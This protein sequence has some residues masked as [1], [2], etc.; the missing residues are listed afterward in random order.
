MTPISQLFRRITFCAFA[1]LIHGL[2][3]SAQGLE[4]KVEASL[5]SYFANFQSPYTQLKS[6]KLDR[7]ELNENQK[8]V[9][10]YPAANFGY[11][12]FTPQSTHTIYEQLR[13]S[14]PAELQNYTLCITC[15][16]K[17]IEE[18]IPNRLLNK[19][20]KERLWNKTAYKGKPWVENQSKPYSLD[21][22]LSNKHL[23]VW[24]SHGIYYKAEKGSWEFQRP[25]LFGTR[26]DLLTKE[27]VVPYLIPMLENAGATVF[28]PRERDYQ[29][30]EVI[31]DNDGTGTFHEK[32]S[33][34][35]KWKT[36]NNRGFALPRTTYLDGESPFREGTT[37]YAK[38]EKKADRAFAQWIPTFPEAGKY[39]VYV[40]YQSEPKSVEDAKYLVFHKGGVTEFLVN[41][42]MGGGTWVYLGSFEFEKGMNETGMV[43]LTNQ[44]KQKG[45]ISADAVRFGGGMGNIVRGGTTS[46]MPRYV[47]G[48]RYW[49]QWAGF[50]YE[51]YSPSE[52]RNDYTDDINV[53]G[54]SVNY[55]NGGSVFNPEEQGL[56]VPIELSFGFHTDAGFSKE[57]DFIGT[58]GIYTTDTNEGN[59]KAGPSRYTARD[60]SDGVLNELN[61]DLT[62]H[63]GRAWSTR[64]MWNRNYSE[65]RIPGVPAMILELLSH[66][67]FADLKQAYDPRFQFVVGRSI[68]KAILK[69]VATMH[70][71]SY[72]V[73]PLPV[74]HFAIQRGSKRGSFQ[75]HWQPVLDALEPTAT[76]ESYVVYTR[77][78]EGGFDN[79]K[80]VTKPEYNFQAEPGL[81]YSFKVTAVNRGGESF[82]SEILAAYQAPQGDKTVLIINNFNRLSGP[83]TIETTTQ[84]GFDLATDTGMPYLQTAAFTGAQRSFDKRYI[85]QES[86][87]G[88]GFSGDELVG[89]V[90]AGNSFD[91]PY[92]HGKAIK[93]VG[94]YSFV[95]ASSA[96]VEQGGATLAEYQAVDLIQGAEKAPLSSTLQA[97]LTNYC[98]R[99]GNLF[100]SGSYLGSS[101]QTATATQFAQEVLKYRAGGSLLGVTQGAVSG[102]ST[103]FSFYTQPNE[104]H[105]AATA[106]DCLLPV[107]PAYSAF[108]Y[109]PQNYSAGVVYQGNYRT[110]VLGFPFETIEQEEA[111]RRIMQAILGFFE[112]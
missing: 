6:C 20:D 53:R 25:A 22:G 75:L 3:L 40:T 109:S 17:P 37:R 94:G 82:P 42:Q 101:L 26:E 10:V 56:K 47:E 76:P 60:L 43:I 13:A 83:A 58:L 31:V 52:G 74:S 111:Q 7:F 11:Q 21:R 45:V 97:L 99:G 59:L 63:L 92:T 106:P 103:H 55:L 61:R 96:A 14:L 4:K 98:N 41:Q 102:A 62:N 44:S 73:Q 89:K 51:V 107:A 79:G 50:P 30:N 91:Y 72:V 104:K 66:Q 110:F 5:K 54:R 67:N 23:A 90:I 80:L 77:I 86:E 69:H 95:S 65:S 112:K 35:G 36:S 16:G 33:S 18:L 108:V 38:T 19:V 57:G 49:A 70:Q 34:K 78:G 15:D 93:A 1:L 2:A 29:R 88:L 64:G 32:K 8:R 24:Q 39:A 48:A 85:G 9:T 105:Y 27:I 87:R 28:T 84:E 68:Y 46:G 71:K 100:V 12:L 81:I